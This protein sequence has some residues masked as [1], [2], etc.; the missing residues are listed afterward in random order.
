M[1]SFYLLCGMPFSGKTTHRNKQPN[2]D[3]TTGK[4]RNYYRNGKNV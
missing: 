3:K 4:T 2:S 1:K